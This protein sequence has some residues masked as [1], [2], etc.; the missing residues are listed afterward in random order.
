MF[1]C[2]KLVKRKLVKSLIF[3]HLGMKWN[4]HTYPRVCTICEFTH[5]QSE[6]EIRVYE[7]FNLAASPAFYSLTIHALRIS[8]VKSMF[9][10]KSSSALLMPFSSFASFVT[11]SKQTSEP[12][13]KQDT[14]RINGARILWKPSYL[15]LIIS[16]FMSWLCWLRSSRYFF[17]VC[18]LC[19]SPSVIPICYGIR[20]C[21]RNNWLHDVNRAYYVRELSVEDSITGTWWLISSP[22]PWND[23]NHLCFLLFY[24]FFVLLVL[25]LSFSSL[26]SFCL[27][28]LVFS[29]PPPDHS[30][31]TMETCIWWIGRQPQQHKCRHMHTETLREVSYYS[32]QLCMTHCYARTCGRVCVVW[33]G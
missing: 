33:R 20:V 12:G 13:R 7:A 3:S 23:V 6:S 25:F 8:K 10:I 26:V 1:L 29:S 32:E 22:R 18:V 15:Q 11:S 2:S 24:L 21:S 16:H 17:F 30:P 5:S 9:D 4:A 28:T 27:I 19:C 14:A 31:K